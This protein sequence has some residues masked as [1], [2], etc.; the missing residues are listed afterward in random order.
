MGMIG[1]VKRRRSWD[2]VMDPVSR[3][4]NVRPNFSCKR[5]PSLMEYIYPSLPSEPPY[6]PLTP[7]DDRWAEI[8]SSARQRDETLTYMHQKQ[9]IL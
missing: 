6:Y 7:D 2:E 3:G 1:A 5:Y 8:C 4:L 9:F